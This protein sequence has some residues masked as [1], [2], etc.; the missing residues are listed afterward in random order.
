[1][2]PLYMEDLKSLIPQLAKLL[3]MTPAAIYERQRALVRAG[4]IEQRPG[5]G[6]GSG[7][8][9]TPHS[10]A[11]LLISIAA[12]GNLSEVE[13]QTK[14]VASLKSRTKRCPLTGKAT[15]ASALT[16]VFESQEFRK[17]AA[18]FY[19]ERGGK[20]SDASIAYYDR[21]NSETPSR[22][23]KFGKDNAH[24][25]GMISVSYLKLPTFEAFLQLK[26]STE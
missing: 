2:V 15:F 11:M 7:V 25:H 9:A 13:Q 6:P 1:M 23:S 16:A 26:E 5:H 22:D 19:V 17:R 4:L 21:P 20:D 8:L 14:I 24:K 3:G 12:T 10:L 18:Y